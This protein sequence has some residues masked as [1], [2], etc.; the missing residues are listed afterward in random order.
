MPSKV[1]S[2]F[3]P[4]NNVEVSRHSRQWWQMW[5]TPVLLQVA[6]RMTV[7]GSF[8]SRKFGHRDDGDTRVRSYLLPGPFA[9][10]AGVATLDCTTR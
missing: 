5:Q 2:K 8:G 1:P 6:L 4:D 3:W 7:H 10:T 9:S